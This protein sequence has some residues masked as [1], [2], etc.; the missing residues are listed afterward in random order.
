MAIS[1]TVSAT[2]WGKSNVFRNL[3]RRN[4]WSIGPRLTACFVALLL[5][6]LALD[7]IAVWQFSRIAV[8]VERLNQADQA[9]LAIVRVH[10]DVY[11]FRDRLLEVASSHDTRQFATEAASIRRKF[12][13]DVAHARELLRSSPTIE[14]DQ[15]ILS[16]L[17]TLHVTLPA[18]LDALME[19]AAAGDWQAMRLRL[20]DQVAS[21]IDLSSMLVER[22]DREVLQV[23]ADAIASLQR[24]RRQLYL[25]GPITALLTLLIAVALGWYTTRSITDPLSELDAGARALARGEFEY[26]VNVRGQDE[27]ARLGKAFNYAT[28]RIRQLYESVLR[29]E[30]QLR[31]VIE[32]IP[33]MAWTAL[34]DGSNAFTNRQWVEYTGL[35]A[36]DTANSGWQAVVHPK[37]LD[38]HVEKW[39]SSL[40]TGRPFENEM[41]LRRAA[42]GKYRWF[43]VRGVP[44]LDE[45][46][47]ILKWYGIAS[48]IEDRKQAEE[49]LR[50]TQAAQFEISLETRVRERTRIARE[51]H[52]TLLQNF[53]GLLLRFQSVLKMLPERP[54]EA[55]Q[56]LE[57]ALH[58]AAQAITDA[59]DAIQG[60]RKL[61]AD[62]DD[63]AQ[64][65]TAVGEELAAHRTDS[66]SPAIHLEVKGTPRNL[67]PVVRDETFGIASEALR[68]AFRHAQ[69]QRIIVE[70][71]YDKQQ[72][73]LRVRDDGKGID[74]EMLRQQSARHFG[75]PG[76][77]ERAE[78]VG[79]S[80]EVS[81]RLG[82]GT[83]VELSIPGSIAYDG[84]PP[85]VRNLRGNDHRKAR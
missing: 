78:I 62:S 54:L 15:M 17:E 21:L 82:S 36:E 73:R 33:A 75:L 19:L 45:Q 12:Q 29:S 59:R 61:V 71:Q 48:D 16:G 31:D 25:V 67:S 14:Q 11:A 13:E 20:A 32:T 66:N 65:V 2:H 39:R 9:S 23:R 35:S 6:M 72:F 70:I 41:R 83:Q 38:R 80:L 42:D 5:L 52:D 22:I 10:L 30:K 85:S 55:R 57:S 43:L 8:A 50:Q 68:N 77:R 74:E 37:D 63:L 56:R 79:G 51:L 53:Q 58:Q 60:L 28:R 18:Q 81:S 7:V 24:T 40:T 4:H 34:P 49:E 69:A 44:Q 64:A 76:M 47:N 3:F 1:D 27:L 84:A 26:E 46:G